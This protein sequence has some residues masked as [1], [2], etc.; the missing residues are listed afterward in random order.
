MEAGLEDD[1]EIVVGGLEHLTQHAVELLLGHRDERHPADEVDVA[2]VVQRVRHLVQP[3]IAAQ[4]VLVDL[5]EVLVRVAAHE[6]LD[7]HALLVHREMAGG[8]EPLL[9]RQLHD[10]GV[11]VGQR[12]LDLPLHEE[13]VDPVHGGLVEV[14]LAGLVAHRG[15]PS[16]VGA[17]SLVSTRTSVYAN[18]AHEG[19]G[20]RAAA[21]GPA[22]RARSG[23]QHL[24]T[25]DAVRTPPPL[26]AGS[27]KRPSCPRTTPAVRRPSSPS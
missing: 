1:V 12:G 13:V 27:G 21:D 4:E 20:A 5:L 25:P 6:R 22:G 10:E 26:H 16:A 3:T 15:A 11:A 18:D 14:G 9:P 7:A 8:L 17:S 24:R 23:R 19:F 2:V